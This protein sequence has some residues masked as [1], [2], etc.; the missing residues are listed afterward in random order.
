MR[1]HALRPPLSGRPILP[2]LQ[3]FGRVNPKFLE[4]RRAPREDVQFSA[5]IDIGDGGSLLDCTVLDV[6]DEGARITLA[7]PVRLPKIFHLVFTRQGT[8]RRR[9]RLVWRVDGEIG[10]NYL[11]PLATNPTRSVV[12]WVCLCLRGLEQPAT[13]RLVGVARR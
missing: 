5:W 12:S 13:S 3:A 10:V 7:S 11:G 4:Q 2:L 9:C 1:S 8:R 6:S